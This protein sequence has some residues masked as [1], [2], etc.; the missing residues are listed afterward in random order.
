MSALSMPLPGRGGLPVLLGF[1]A[2][3]VT[4]LRC[5][6]ELARVATLPTFCKLFQRFPLF[7][8]LLT[9]GTTL[10]EVGI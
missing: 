10:H 4:L 7:K 5:G 6:R 1:S 3:L 9:F 2:G 8:R